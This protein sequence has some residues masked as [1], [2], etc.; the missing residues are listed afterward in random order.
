MIFK[1]YNEQNIENIKKFNVFLFYGEIKAK[2][3]F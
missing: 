3:R 1:S 2:E